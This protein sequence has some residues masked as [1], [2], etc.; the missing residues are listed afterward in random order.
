MQEWRNHKN[1]SPRV[2]SDDSD[3]SIYVFLWHESL[4]PFT[5]LFSHGPVIPIYI[6]VVYPE[7][8]GMVS[9]FPEH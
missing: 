8:L 3:I 1:T 4:I 9:S 5:V 7:S 6:G 2:R